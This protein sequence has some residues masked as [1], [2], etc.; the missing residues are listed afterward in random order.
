MSPKDDDKH[1]TKSEKEPKL[2]PIHIEKQMYKVP[3]GEISAEDLR[4]LPEPDIGSDRDLYREVP[5]QAEDDLVEAGERVTVKEGMRF[6]T[7]PSTI[8]P[9]RAA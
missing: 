2:V 4:A 9:G 5:G 8:S 3:E 7:A 6:F 1:E